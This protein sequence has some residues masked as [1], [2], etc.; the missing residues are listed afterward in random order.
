M[1]TTARFADVLTFVT[2]A[3]LSFASAAAVATYAP[4]PLL[5]EAAVTVLP[6]VVVVSKSAKVHQLPTVLVVAK[7][8]GSQQLAQCQSPSANQC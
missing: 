6:T 4:A 5:E 1:T 3:G 2:M 8:A 7:R